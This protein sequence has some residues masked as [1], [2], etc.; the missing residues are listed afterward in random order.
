ME[1]P[2]E[3]RILGDNLPIHAD[4]LK[5][6]HHGSKTS[7][8]DPFLDAVMPSFAVISNGFENSFH[9]PHAE[10]LERLAAHHAGIL[11]TDIEG[12]VTLRTYGDRMYLETFRYTSA[13]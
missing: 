12:L 6:G 11:R 4:V 1:K 2:M 5:V 7:S 13:R 9:H 10:T 8:I 3:L